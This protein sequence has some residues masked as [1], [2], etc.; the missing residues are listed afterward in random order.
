VTT[1]DYPKEHPGSV[2]N[3]AI[4]LIHIYYGQGTGKTTKAVGQAIRAA[5]TGLSVDFVQFLKSGNSG[6]VTILE[7][8][9]NLHY[10]CAGDHPFIISRGPEQIHYKHAQKALG[11]ALEA[12]ERET[13]LLICDEVLDTLLFKLLKKEQI[14]DLMKR[15]KKKVELIMTGRDAPREFI[16][17]ADYVVELIEVKHPYYRG[18]RAR[19]GIEY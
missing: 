17:L 8:I 4:G 12:T 2:D 13:D 3:K 19:R 16:E 9:P 6:E 10:W 15:C 14:S 18:A 5:G 7:K 11:Y 1:I